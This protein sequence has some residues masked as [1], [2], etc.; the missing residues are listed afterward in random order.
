M[1]VQPTEYDPTTPP[2]PYVN[3]VDKAE[4][5]ELAPDQSPTEVEAV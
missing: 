4:G 1:T 2:V 3:D 5:V